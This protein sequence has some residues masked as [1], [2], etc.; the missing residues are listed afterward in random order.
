MSIEKW[1]N[2][3]EYREKEEYVRMSKNCPGEY[4]KRVESVLVPKNGIIRVSTGKRQ[5]P[6]ECR[7]P[8][9]GST[10]KGSNLCET[11]KMAESWSVPGKGRICASVEKLSRGVPKKGRFYVSTKKWQNRGKYREKVESLRVSNNCPG[12]CRKRVESV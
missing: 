10:K 3:G 1:Q 6:C 8:V 5:N 9:P 7:K 4:R 11:R 12:E 2:P